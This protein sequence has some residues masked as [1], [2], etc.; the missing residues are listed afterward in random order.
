[1]SCNPSSVHNSVCG[2]CVSKDLWQTCIFLSCM[3]HGLSC[4][5]R[6]VSLRVHEEIDTHQMDSPAI[7]Q[8]Q[9][10]TAA[11]SWDIAIEFF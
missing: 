8:F 10:R 6:F 9:A 1:M 2:F 3:I 11:V 4:V 7:L 5:T